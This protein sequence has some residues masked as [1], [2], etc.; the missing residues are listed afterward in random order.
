MRYRH[1]VLLGSFTVCLTQ[2]PMS[3]STGTATPISNISITQTPLLQTDLTTAPI[4]TITEPVVATSDV[5]ETDLDTLRAEQ[6]KLFLK[7]EQYIKRR[8]KK[9]YEASLAEIG[10]YPLVP[11][12]EYQWLKKNLGDHAGIDQF[13]T[14]HA[15][16]RYAWP[17]R[18]RWL[19]KLAKQRKWQDFLGA[20]RP[21]SDTAL[22]CQ[23]ARAL[24]NTGKK[25]A[26]LEAGADLWKVGKSQPKACDPIF[27][28]MMDS[29]LFT[30]ELKWQRFESA[31]K[32]G[33]TRLAKYIARMLPDAERETAK[34]WRKLHSN[35]EKHLPTLLEATGSEHDNKMFAHAIRRMAR[36]DV[37]QAVDSWEQHAQRFDISDD[38]R[39]SIER[40]LGMNLAFENDM[41][42]YDRLDALR[43]PDNKSLE[44]M[45]R[46]ALVNQDWDRVI[47]TIARL[48]N[49]S[50]DSERWQYWLARGYAETGKPVQAD[51]IFSRLAG[52]RDYFGY[53]AAER[54]QSDYQLNNEPLNVSDAEVKAVA[55]K[56]TFRMAFELMALDREREAKLQWW[57]AMK[58]ID[59]SR[60]P[61]AAKLAQRWL[62]DEIAILT[63]AKVKQWDDIELRFPIRYSDEVH[64]NAEINDLDP[65][66]VFG[67]IR[68]E[69]VFNDDARSHVG[70]RG[71]MQ[72]MPRTARQVSKELNYRW[73]GNA[74]LHEVDRNITFG[75]YYLKKLLDRFNGNH[76]LALAAYNAGPQRVKRWLPDE[77]MPADIW[78]ESIPINE[79][80]EYVSHVLVYSMI[81]Q[82]LL[83]TDE[84]KLAELAAV[85]EPPVDVAQSQ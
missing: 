75:T 69:S 8:N 28:V 37:Y 45:I 7:A 34:L 23:H 59:R 48:D 17:L 82:Q 74:K 80:R 18:K 21:T 65:S 58:S 61:A 60:I 43:K 20:W 39:D 56:E 42:A 26:A 55:N 44:W 19:S 29:D 63:I 32:R 40:K 85:I 10:D 2:A 46:T 30:T 84:L 1:L 35:P 62:W 6:R 11:V 66:L 49:K 53:L 51:E 47:E 25:Q 77:T 16:T 4:S 72:L 57:H 70:A 12:L 81:Y 83:G 68:R 22:N 78:V 50:Q 79:T 41:A 71:L 73:R 15:D 36:T 52:E 76:A 27:A 67:L 5:D 13:L 14:E 64:A 54:L 38:D 33:N 31:L 24:Y 3:F 9:A